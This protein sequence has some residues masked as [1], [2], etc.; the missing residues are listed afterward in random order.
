MCKALRHAGPVRSPLREGEAGLQ[1]LRREAEVRLKAASAQATLDASP[2]QLAGLLHELQVRQIE[3]ELQNEDLRQ[4]QDSLRLAARVFEHCYDAIVVTDARN[5]IVDVNP[6]FTRITGYTRDEVL[7][8][9]PSMLA[10]GMS[11][12]EFYAD[13]WGSLRSKDFWSGEIW[14]RR[15]DGELYAESLSISVIR[16]DQG[17][18]QHHVSVSTDISR[19]KRHQAELDRIANYDLLTGLP[20]RRLFSDRIKQ[21]MARVSRSGDSLAVCYLDLDGFKAINDQF[22]HSVGDAVLMAVSQRL[23][24]VLRAGDTVARLG[25]DEFV[26]LADLGSQAEHDVLL[27]RVLTEVAAPLQVAGHSMAVSVSVGV[28]FYPQDDSDADTLLRHADQAM[29]IA[30]SGGRNRFRVFNLHED[31]QAQDRSQQ[32]KRLAQALV[33]GEF[34]LVYQPKVDL[35]NGQVLGLE[36]LIRWA[37]PSEGLLAPAVF[38]SNLEGTELEGQ[39]GEWVIATALAQMAQWRRQ[40]LDLVCS[41]NI[42]PKH[43]LQVDFSERLAHLLAQCPEVPPSCLELEILE[44]TALD[45]VAT[46]A[47]ALNHCHAMGVRFALDDFGTGYSSLTY[48]RSLPVDTLKVDQCFVLD[49]L[50]DANDCAIVQ[51]VVMLAKTF[52]RH[53]IAEGVETLAH[54]AKLIEL[55]CPSCQGYGIARPMPPE[56]VLPWVQQWGR[57]QPWLQVRAAAGREAVDETV[58]GR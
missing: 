24:A 57:T 27:N 43:L 12:R 44:S 31:R 49:M 11:T 15:K 14:N 6:A 16:D 35:L 53:V 56:D 28:T 17:E 40:G 33:A 3:L 48:C 46:A 47:Q 42:S 54:G 10:S 30:K 58:S 55:G 5:L 36:A 7:G 4:S 38:L 8:R 39:V 29:Y 52:G 25:G 9:G 13:L 20:N 26:L 32:L 37:H 50:Q 41:V 18:I 51:A 2:A 21:A 34:R 19:M 22:G 1:A 23:G 45:D